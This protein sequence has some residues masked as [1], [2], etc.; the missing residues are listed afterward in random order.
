VRDELTRLAG[1]NKGRFASLALELL[2]RGDLTLETDGG[3]KP[4]DEIVS[5]ALERGAAVATLDSEL[6]TR[7]RASRVPLITLREGRVS[8]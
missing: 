6:A 3:G 5:F 4:D 2:D 7:L 8:I 1:V